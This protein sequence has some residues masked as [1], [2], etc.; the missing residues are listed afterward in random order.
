MKEEGG[1]NII[2]FSDC[3][4]FPPAHCVFYWHPSELCRE[5]TLPKIVGEHHS[6][7]L[8]PSSS[9]FETYCFLLGQKELL[10]F[11]EN[12]MDYSQDSYKRLK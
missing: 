1:G 6:L 9:Q 3:V 8:T 11:L 7:S 5:Q 12:M 10:I 2:F 4:L